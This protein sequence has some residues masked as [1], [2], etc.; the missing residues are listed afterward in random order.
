MTI[1]WNEPENFY[2]SP[3]KSGFEI[4]GSVDVAD[5]YEFDIL[6]VL[7]DKSGYLFWCHDSGCSCPV[8]F[9][10][11]TIND[12]HPITRENL[13]EFEAVAQ[14]HKPYAYSW[15]QNISDQIAWDDDSLA[16]FSKVFELI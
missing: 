4:V 9:E 8:P 7:K 11:T 15:D 16:L 5:S 13:K 1:D 3:E 6:L 10:S 14:K 12:L 2:Y